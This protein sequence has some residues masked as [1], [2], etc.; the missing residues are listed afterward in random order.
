MNNEEQKKIIRKERKKGLFFTILCSLITFALGISFAAHFGISNNEVDDDLDNFIY[1]Y[2]ILK[3]DWYF[4]DDETTEEALKAAIEAIYQANRDIDPYT[5][6]TE[7]PVIIGDSDKPS[8]STPKPPVYYGIGIATR[9]SVDKD[10]H[11]SEEGLVVSEV[12]T[13]GGSHKVLKIGDQILGCYTEAEYI[14]F[15]GKV[16]EDIEMY[17]KSTEQNS[18][19]TLHIL[20]NGNPMDVEVTRKSYAK[21]YVFENEVDK[22]TCSNCLGIRITNFT[23]S[24]SIEFKDVLDSMVEREKENGLKSKDINLILDLRDNPGGYVT[25]F[26]NIADYFLPSGLDLLHYEYKD[27]HTS[28]GGKSISGVRYEFNTITILVNEKT[29]SASEGLT[30]A[31][32]DYSEYL[33]DKVQVVGVKSFGKGIAQN[34]VPLPDGSSIRYTFARTLSP[35]KYSIHGEGIEPDVEIPYPSYNNALTFVNAWSEQFDQACA[36]AVI[37]G[38]K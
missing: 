10:N 21:N 36:Q 23:N 31:L 28:V 35:D 27:G 33:N 24:S 3:N 6:F 1:Y 11:L 25:S 14:S 19:L 4:G 26:T 9:I 8:T 37:L 30:L 2:N 17:I 20:R 38:G 29:A 22:N 34:E 15:V 12:Y 16:Y 5:Y 13:K 32:V 18:K 7:A